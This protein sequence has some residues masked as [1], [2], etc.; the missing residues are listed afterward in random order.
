VELEPADAVLGDQAAG[1]LDARGAPAG[2][3]DS[4][5]MITSGSSA[6]CAAS[7]FGTGGC[8]VAAGVRGVVQVRRHA[9][10]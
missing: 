10:I 1:H 8:P 2:S 6:D 5:G 3:T 7:S 4:N 9:A